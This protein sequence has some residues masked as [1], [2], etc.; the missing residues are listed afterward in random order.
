MAEI[1][2]DFQVFDLQR[3]FL[4][5]LPWTFTCEVMVRTI[6]MYLYTLAMVRLL[7]KRAVGQLSLIEFLL[8]I[9]LGSAV[10]DPMFY[11]DVPLL[12]CMAVI[13]VVVFLHYGLTYAI[14]YYEKIERIL[15]GEPCTL[16]YAGK[17]LPEGLRK[18]RMGREELFES[19]RL[20]G[21]EHLGQVREAY[22]EQ[23]G[24]ISVFC[25]APAL[26]QAGM[27]LTPPWDL[28][29]PRRFWSGQL[30]PQTMPL[31]CELCG[32]IKH[33]SAAQYL[34]VCERCEGKQWVDAISPALTP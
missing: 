14:T 28:E 23:S 1:P 4:G 24:H 25:Y 19:L 32:N 21:I 22:F 17:M 33:F 13:T 34:P 5:D 11:H 20:Q 16:V 7:S 31:A 9:A 18:A 29:E 30:A 2:A 12:H 26:E 10:G 15:E 6:F 8:V 27:R 3:M